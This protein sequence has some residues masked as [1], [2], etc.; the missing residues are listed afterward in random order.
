MAQHIIKVT[1]VPATVVRGAQQVDEVRSQRQ[2]AEAQQAQMQQA[3]MTAEAA[4]NVAPAIIAGDNAS[5]EMQ[6]GMAALMGGMGG[7]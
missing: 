6:E 1:N 5:P 7:Q 3:A 2:Q 4:G